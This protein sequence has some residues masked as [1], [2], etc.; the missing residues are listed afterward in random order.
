VASAIAIEAVARA[1]FTSRRQIPASLAIAFEAANRAI[2]EYGEKHPEC[3]GMGTTCTALAIREGKAWLAHVGDS[4]A[5]LL[6]KGQLGRLTE[7]QTLLAQMIR[8]GL[9]TE[10]E[11]KTARG[12]N[13]LLQ[14][15]GTGPHAGPS[16]TNEPISLLA[17]DILILCTDGL[18]SMVDDA[19]IARLA[20][21][22]PPREACEN[23]INAALDAGGFDNVSVAVFRFSEPGHDAPGK[24]IETQ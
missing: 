12:R 1:Y 17:G 14:A 21:Q 9:I 13:I 20:S 11:A 4:R 19:A 16:I 22:A 8:D 10:G 6:R 7:D 18:W 5:Y 23:L 24:G 3:Q 15:L 2:F